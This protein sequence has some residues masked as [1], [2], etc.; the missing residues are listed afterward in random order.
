RCPWRSPSWVLLWLGP[1]LRVSPVWAIT[2]ASSRSGIA[3]RLCQT[4]WRNQSYN[5]RRA[6]DGSGVV[7]E[8]DIERGAHHFVGVVR[9]RILDDCDV[10]AK[11]RSIANGCFY[12]S[13]RDE[14]D[15]Y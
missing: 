14:A 3:R 13:V 4:R 6:D 5:F 2:A 1:R 9:G 10:V 7:R 12:T 11:L 8:I 15:D